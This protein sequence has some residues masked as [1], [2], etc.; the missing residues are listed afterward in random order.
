MSSNLSTSQLS[1]FDK[2][3]FSSVNF[4]IS[5]NG[6]PNHRSKVAFLNISGAAWTESERTIIL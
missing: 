6:R 5:V 2:I 4:W 1:V 3:P